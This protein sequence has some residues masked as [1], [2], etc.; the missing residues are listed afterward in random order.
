M[1]TT[2]YNQYQNPLVNFL[3]KWYTYQK[4]RFPVL[5]HGLLILAF[6]FSAVSFAIIISGSTSFISK[7]VFIPGAFI[8]FTI[9]LQL[10]IFDEFKDA[11]DD[12]KYRSHLPVP[13]GLVTLKEL[14]VI[15]LVLFVIQI[16]VHLIFFPKMLILFAMVMT[17]LFFMNNEF[18][19]AEWLRKNQFWYVVSHM[20]IIPLVDVYASG[21]FWFLNDINPPQGLIFFFIVSFFNGV[22]LEIGR[23]IKSPEQESTGVLTY[24]SMLGS[25]RATLLWLMIIVAT[26]IFSIVCSN[27][28]QHNFITY[29]MLVSVL[30]V[31]AIPAILYLKYKSNLTSKMIEVASA[32]W[33]IVMYL[34]LGGLPMLQNLF[35]K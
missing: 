4:V 30:I 25:T 31:C 11:D 15:A 7:E 32:L 2:I 22:V 26:F 13:S 28:A 35:T 14:K 29:I 8:V 10:R 21:L 9:F 17:Y 5:L 6:S 16:T 24:S 33:T 23:K 34:A 12:K 27:Y 18:F 19:I 3:Y 20:M 1:E